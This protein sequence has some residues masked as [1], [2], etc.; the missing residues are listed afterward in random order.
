[1][2]FKLNSSGSWGTLHPTPTRYLFT[3]NCP[4]VEML[5]GLCNLKALMR[6]GMFLAHGLQHMGVVLKF[7]EGL[8]KGGTIGNTIP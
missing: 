1:M 4:L 6:H 3:G 2:R 8:C 7:P 5:P